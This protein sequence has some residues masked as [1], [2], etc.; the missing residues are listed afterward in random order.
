M[1]CEGTSHFVSDDDFVSFARRFGPLHSAF[2]KIR[3]VCGA[4]GEAC[5]WFLK[6]ATKDDTDNYF[7]LRANRDQ[8][9]LGVRLYAALL[10]LRMLSAVSV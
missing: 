2:D 8:K 5:D 3:G 10:F 6:D 1:V 4:N 9:Q 7:K